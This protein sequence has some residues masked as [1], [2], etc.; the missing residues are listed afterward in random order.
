MWR[1]SAIIMLAVIGAV[2]P[3]YGQRF[4]DTPENHWAYDAIAELAAKGLIEGY[5]DG[6]FI[7]DRAMTRYEMAVVVARLLARIETL[8]IPTPSA[9]PQPQVT[10]ADIDTTLRL[11]Q[12]FRADLTTMNVRVASVEVELNAIKGRLDSVRISG[13]VRFGENLLQVANGPSIN[14]NP[15]T[16]SNPAGNTA[17][18][19]QVQ[20]EFKLM[21]DASVS[22]DIHF[23]VALETA[24]QYQIFNS[25]NFGFGGGPPGQGAFGSIDSAFLDWKNAFGMPLEFW[26]GRFGATPPCHPIGFG[27]SLLFAL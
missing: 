19:N 17:R 27:C 22:P 9:P 25:S 16:G 8:Q 6:T 3:V 11:G 23:I 5:P 13:A 20:M 21:F 1:V 26:L 15:L 4:S 10:K 14:G 12:E 24:N 2:T 7:G 18:G